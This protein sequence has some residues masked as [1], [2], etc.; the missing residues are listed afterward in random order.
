MTKGQEPE[1]KTFRIEKDTNWI[2]VFFLTAWL[3]VWLIMVGFL[4]YGQIT[5]P[6]RFPE[7]W[8]VLAATIAVG[9]FAL[10]TWLWQVRGVEVIRAFRDRLKVTKMGSFA[11]GKTCVHHHE[12]DGIDASIDETTPHWLRWWGLG[13]GTIV[14]SYLGRSFRCGQDLSMQRATRIARELSGLY[15]D[16]LKDKQATV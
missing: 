14:L 10:R 9:I 4:G 15:R 11:F 5:N 12:L 6:T 8:L 2:L 3:I 7:L 13:G 16:R 1:I